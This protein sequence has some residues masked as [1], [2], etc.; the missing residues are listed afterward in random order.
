MGLSRYVARASY[1][2]SLEVLLPDFLMIVDNI[3]SFDL[4]DLL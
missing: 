2:V 3:V 4:A 1:A